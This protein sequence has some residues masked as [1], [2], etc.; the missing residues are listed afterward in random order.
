MPEL[1]EDIQPEF[2]KRKKQADNSEIIDTFEARFPVGSDEE[3]AMLGLQ[4]FNE[5]P[6]DSSLLT[7]KPIGTGIEIPLQAVRGVIKGIESEIK[8][9]AD[10]VTTPLLK[11]SG[12]LEVEQAIRKQLGMDPI[13]TED[14]E[15][16]IDLPKPGEAETKIGEFTQVISRF[17][18]GFAGAGKLLKGVEAVGI[19]AKAAK[20]ALQ[21][22]LADTLAFEG[23]EE[24]LANMLNEFP[25]LAGPTT[26]F[27]STSPDNT[28]AENKLK[29]FYEGLGLG[30]LT[31]GLF[32]GVM[33]IR[34]S[35]AAKRA[36]ADSDKA[37]AATEI[38]K[39]ADELEFPS[40]TIGGRE[41]SFKDVKELSRAEKL[42]DN[43]FLVFDSRT[44]KGFEG[45]FSTAEEA[46][47]F[48]KQSPD[49]KHFDFGTPRDIEELNPSGDQSIAFIEERFSRIVKAARVANEDTLLPLDLNNLLGDSLAPLVDISPETILKASKSGKF[50]GNIN[51][52]RI[53]TTED[54][55]SVFQIIGEAIAPS[56]KK[57][58]AALTR[59][60]NAET[61]KLAESLDMTVDELLRRTGEMTP[62]RIVAARTLLATSA[63][64]LVNLAKIANSVE[65]S[66]LDLVAFRQSMAL[67]A[68][69]QQEVSGLTTLA[70]RNLQSFNITV[71]SKVERD[72]L[73]KDLLESSGG[74][75]TSRRMAEK[76]AQATDGLTPRE[77]NH[78]SRGGLGAKT[79]DAFLEVWINGLLSNPATFTV[80]NL[81]GNA[82]SVMWSI[83]DRQTAGAI[84][85]LTGEQGVARDEAVQQMY[86]L[87]KG[88]RKG[89]KL[90]GRTLRTG[91][92]SDPLTK[93]ELS[94]PRALSS[95]EFNVTGISGQ[96]ADFIATYIINAPSRSLLSGDE[97]F[98]SIGYEME[99]SALALRKGTDEG[100][101]GNELAKRI[102][103]IEANPAGEIKLAAQHQARYQTFTKPLGQGGKAVQG[104]INAH[105]AFRLVAPFVRTPLNLVKFAGERSPLALASKTVRKELAAGGA[106]KQLAMAKISTGS[107]LMA[108]MADLAGQDIITGH[109]PLDPEMRAIWLVNH[110]PNAV[111]VGPEW[112]GY[113]RTDPVGITMG[114]A[115]D[116]AE[117]A[118]H[119]DD[120]ELGTLTLAAVLAIGRNLTNKTYVKN[121]SE[122]MEII[123]PGGSIDQLAPVVKSF[124]AKTLASGVPFSS[125]GAAL[126]RDTDT[127]RRTTRDDISTFNQ[128][129]NEIKTKTRA[130]GLLGYGFAS[131]LPPMR[132]V[133]GDVIVM[134][135]GLGPDMISPIYTSSAAPDP[136]ADELVKHGV[137][138]SWPSRQIDEVPLSSKEYDRY[139]ELSGGFIRELLGREFQKES[140]Q[141]K[142][143]GQDGRKAQ[144]IKQLV[145]GARERARIEMRKD[146]EFETL[147]QDVRK[148]FDNKKK[149]LKQGGTIIPARP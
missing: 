61:K 54:I 2:V 97:L 124:A 91:E 88:F 98:K 142:S 100:L 77:L 113:G 132:N 66:P 53:K 55:E 34:A 117:I 118:G 42:P 136:I 87:V 127:V 121:V 22:G 29:R 122:F 103:D 27:L 31:D 24:N 30:V 83:A 46:K 109:G 67:H 19:G 112:F 135:G 68:A 147:K 111:R 84:A 3:R 52:G 5:L 10:L 90:A 73:V 45:I 43:P 130:V 69:I 37:R 58:G 140:Y 114:M 36:L 101:Q 106:R 128:V 104:F 110:Q 7:D 86:G 146:P 63:D 44:E 11:A 149:T 1:D 131:D 50:E 80:L 141:R 28:V 96:A 148:Q 51:L 14:P 62:Q 25:F 105:P 116:F 95:N 134:S 75:I 143:N 49:G 120:E 41:L 92:V 16:E 79:F 82:I 138:I 39:A 21:G 108:A 144:R 18:T 38:E 65:G 93:I 81:M 56:L 32:A 126:Q 137:P 139:L 26:E 123:S 74:E 57:S 78:I 6:A 33:I 72:Q 48:I 13:D 60:T 12:L 115:A 102:L 85:R 47:A 8:T 119:L 94:K 129:L 35:R 23:S 64:K 4:D 40:V 9:V 107:L 15:F 76:I 20:S 133:L 89:L 125:F 70:G 99:L 59:Q 145:E 71:G 17:I